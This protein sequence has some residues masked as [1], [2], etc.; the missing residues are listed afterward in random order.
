MVLNSGDRHDEGLPEFPFKPFLDDFQVQEAEKAT[1]KSQAKGRGG[2]FL[3]DQ[4][5]VIQF[6]FF[7]GLNQTLIILGRNRVD[8]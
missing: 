7:K 3:K 5:S 6:I 8:R 2:V 4:G 1:A